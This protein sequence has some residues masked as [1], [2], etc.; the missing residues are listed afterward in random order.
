M[1]LW[2]AAQTKLIQNQKENLIPTLDEYLELGREI[3]GFNMVL[4]LSELLEITQFPE[5][6]REDAQNLLKLKQTAF[7]VIAWSKV[8]L[9]STLTLFMVLIE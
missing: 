9:Y 4:D 1:Q 5:L 3:N 7:N 6:Q 8:L 2:Q